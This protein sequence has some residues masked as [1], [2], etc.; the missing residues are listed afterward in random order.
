MASMDI[1]RE[2]VSKQYGGA[3]RDKVRRMP[4]YQVSAIYRTMLD[5]L[6]KL[7]RTPSRKILRESEVRGGDQLSF[8]QDNW[9]TKIKEGYL[10]GKP[11][12]TAE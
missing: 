7:K 2:Y 3:W 12:E 11:V 9:S 10:N 4:D 8:F 6:D 1:M 5:K